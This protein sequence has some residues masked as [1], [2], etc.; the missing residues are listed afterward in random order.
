MHIIKR[1]RETGEISVRKGQGRR[2]LLDACGLR[3]LRP[4]CITHRHDFVID[5]TKWVQEYFQKPLSVNIICRAICRCQLNFYHAKREPNV[6]MVQKRCHVLWAK[7]PLQW[8]VSKWKSVLWSD[9]SK[10]DVLVG[11]HGFCVLRAKEEGDL[12][13]CHPRSVQ[14]PVSLM[15]WGSIS[16]YGMVS[17]L[18]LEGTM[19]AERYIQGFRATYAPLQI[20]SISWK[21]LCIS[22]GQCKTTYCFIVEE[23]VCWIDLPAS[24]NEKYAKDDHKLFSSW[25]PITGKNGTKIQNRNSRN[26]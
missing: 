25:K 12:P 26:S 6:N 8:T 23:S 3:A 20:T 9:E 1:F 7:S 5:I 18:V 14:K 24:L 4:H 10:F 11:N 13:A 17:L 22:A 16:A 21:A 2:P 19:N 15:V